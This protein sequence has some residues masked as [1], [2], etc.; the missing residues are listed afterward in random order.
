M[1]H[2]KYIELPIIIKT[3]SGLGDVYVD[4][5]TVIGYT[6]LTHKMREESRPMTCTS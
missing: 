5:Y 6:E 2:K 4:Y 3:Q 1:T